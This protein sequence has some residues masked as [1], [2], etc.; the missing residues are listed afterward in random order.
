MDPLALLSS[1]VLT[2]DSA[3]VNNSG[4]SIAGSGTGISV[5]TLIV[6]IACLIPA[7]LVSVSMLINGTGPTGP[8]SA[9]LLFW[10]G[11]RFFALGF[12][13]MVVAIVALPIL[14]LHYVDKY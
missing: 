11:L 3:S 10:K 4:V 2:A 1:S 7:L 8:T 13:Y 9:H 5:S 14:G 12:G 6:T